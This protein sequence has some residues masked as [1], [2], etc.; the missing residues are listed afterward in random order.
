M[1]S[2]WGLV[3]VTLGWVFLWAFLDK[4]MG[5]SFSTLASKSW[6]AGGSPTYGF[7]SNTKGPFADLFHGLA[8]QM[9][10][11]WLFML[12]L[13]GIGVALILG[14]GMRLA[15]YAGSL[16]LFMMWMASLPIKTN[17]FVDDHIVY[18]LVLVGLYVSKSGDTFGFGKS[19]KKSKLVKQYPILQ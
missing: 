18:I 12:G 4:L 11:D 19:W 1:N 10:V 3:R 8:G 17:P 9:W 6:L 15:A 14:I 16:L 5:L 7:L 2:I 13:L